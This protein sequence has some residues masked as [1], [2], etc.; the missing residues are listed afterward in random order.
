M[1]KL[2]REELLYA[3]AILNMFKGGNYSLK[4]EELINH[5][6]NIVEWL[7]EKNLLIVIKLEAEDRFIENRIVLGMRALN[8]VEIPS[9]FGYI[10]KMLEEIN[11]EG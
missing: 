5:P 6:S 2:T 1:I 7:K 9:V 4:T 10:V 11:N 3:L 8:L